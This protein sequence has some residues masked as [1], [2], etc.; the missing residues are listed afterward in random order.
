MPLILASSSPRRRELLRAA[1]F[2]FQVTPST[3]EEVVQPGESPLEFARRTAR[4][5]AM[6]VAGRAGR[7]DWVL[8]ADTIVALNGQILGKPADSAD[9]ARMLRLLSGAEHEVITGVCL[10]RPPASLIAIQSEVT[11]VTFRPLAEEEI[12]A[13]IR[14]GE[15]MDKAGAY[16][17]QGLAS[18]FVT[19]IEGCY[20]NVVGLPISRVDRMLRE[21][22]A[23]DCLRDVLS[24]P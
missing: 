1:G 6:E 4:D 3:V 8:G 19:H 14:S 21:H 16:G 13:Y 10:A 2:E 18:R 24:P 20:F 23:I 15:P 22:G 9:A 11:R 17:V 7:G 5:K 12:S